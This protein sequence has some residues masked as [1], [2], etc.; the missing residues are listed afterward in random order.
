MDPV[1][2][3]VA[4]RD[5]VERAYRHAARSH[6]EGDTDIGH[7]VAVARLL[8][9]AGFGEDAIAAALLH[10]VVEDTGEG[11][12]SLEAE[13]GGEVAGIVEAMT[14]DAAIEDYGE[15]KR[16]HR[17]RV[18]AAG[19]VPAAMYAADKVA[20]VRAFLDSGEPVEPKR[21]AHYR[22]TLEEFSAGRPALPFLPELRQELPRLEEREGRAAGGG[23]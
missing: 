14:E 15:R 10:D 18:L 11:L 4:G 3:F 5:R 13:F 23:R 17:A 8:D 9:E 6:S 12:G 7:P 20:R 19:E 16:E 21:M 22:D 1:P 2:D